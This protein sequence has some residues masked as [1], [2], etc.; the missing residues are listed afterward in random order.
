M[1]AV[2]FSLSFHIITI[3]YQRLICHSLPPREAIVSSFIPVGAVGM[4][5][6]ALLNLANAADKH[7]RAYYK[8]LPDSAANTACE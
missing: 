7:L 8:Q 6:W 3:Y 5:G 1:L 4:A 2:G